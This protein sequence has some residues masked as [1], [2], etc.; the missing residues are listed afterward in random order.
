MARYVNIHIQFELL[1][2]CNWIVLKLNQM[3]KKTIKNPTIIENGNEKKYRLL[4]F[5]SIKK[6]K[7][8]LR[9]LTIPI[10]STMC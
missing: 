10:N 8:P 1:K 5:F 3:N 9:K 4:P 2:H 6:P 7:K